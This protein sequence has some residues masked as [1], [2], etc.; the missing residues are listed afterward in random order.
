M[1]FW[2]LTKSF[3][4]LMWMLWWSDLESLTSNHL[5]SGHN[6]CAGSNPSQTVQWDR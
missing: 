6:I 5:L 4:Y 1:V 2:L 3:Q